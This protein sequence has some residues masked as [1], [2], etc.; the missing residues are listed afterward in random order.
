VYVLK[1][2]R[3]EEKRE[4]ERERERIQEGKVGFW[5]CLVVLVGV[6]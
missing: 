3:G 4:R 1:R 5:W 2:K 6:E